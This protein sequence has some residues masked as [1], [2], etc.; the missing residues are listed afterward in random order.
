MPFMILGA[1]LMHTTPNFRPE[2]STPKR[3]GKPLL[4]GLN[5]L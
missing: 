2:E 5:S 3:K 4:R 1:L